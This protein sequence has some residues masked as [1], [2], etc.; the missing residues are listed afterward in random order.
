MLKR[1]MHKNKFKN[2]N[3]EKFAEKPERNSVNYPTYTNTQY[4]EKLIKGF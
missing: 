1:Y 2:L 3:Q 4:Y